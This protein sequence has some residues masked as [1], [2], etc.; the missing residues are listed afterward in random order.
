LTN[1]SRSPSTTVT[2]RLRARPPL[3]HGGG[4]LCAGL[5][6]EAL[7]WLEHNLEPGMHTLETGCG[8]STVVFAARRTSHVTI[9]PGGDEWARLVRYC[10]EEGIGLETVRFIEE[11]S[12]VALAE[13]WVPEPLDVVL[14]DGAHGFPFAILDWFHTA[15]HLRVGG[16]VL[17]DDAFLPSVNTLARFLR[18]SDSWE[19]ETVLGGRTPCFCKLDDAPPSFDWVG[20][21]FDRWPR[22]DYLPLA[23]RPLALARH[24]LLDRSPLRVLVGNAVQRRAKRQQP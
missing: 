24:W 4:D 5:A 2:R 8:A 17:V 9:T 22:F 12:H 20:S 21:R 23:R 7:E 3:V 13:T 6:W 18:R 11:P 15:P 1:T 19:L 14:I 16:R 10:E